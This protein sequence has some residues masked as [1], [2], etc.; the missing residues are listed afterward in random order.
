MFGTPTFCISIVFSFSWELKWPQEKLKTMLIQIFGVK[1]TA[2]WYVMVF[3]GVVNCYSPTG[4]DASPSQGYK[5]HDV[6][7]DQSLTWRDHVDKIAK[8]A[9][10]GIG[11]LRRVRH[12]ISYHTLITMFKSIVLP[13]FDYCSIVGELWGRDA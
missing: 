3:S 7:I 5:Y 1:Q 8:K 2:L 10:G 9:S 12:L 11:V 13:Y 4:R 6:E